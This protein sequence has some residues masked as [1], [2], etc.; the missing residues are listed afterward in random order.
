LRSWSNAPRHLESHGHGLTAEYRIWSN[1][2][3]RCGNPKMPAYVNYGARGISICDEWRE[4]YE[5]FL[6]DVGRRPSSSHSIDR[7]NNS[8]N[9]EPG[10]VRW[11]DRSEQARNNRRNIMVTAFG[12]TKCVA[13]WADQMGMVRKTL[14]NRIRAGVPPEEAMSPDYVTPHTRPIEAFGRTQLLADWARE[15]GIKSHTLQQRIEKL[16]WPVE[17][18]LTH[19]VRT[20]SRQYRKAA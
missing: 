12:E 18:A 3:Q 20:T 14:A 1:I 19:P 6:R 4:S 8:G 7:I 10:N 5:A 2:K 11:S 13:D 16:G 17:V 9:Y 15:T